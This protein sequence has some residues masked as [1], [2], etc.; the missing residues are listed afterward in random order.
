MEMPVLIA[1]G[2]AKALM[3]RL[4]DTHSKDPAVVITADQIVLYKGVIRE[5]PDDAEMAVHYL[6][7]YNFDK[8]STVSAV[9]VTHY[10]SGVQAHGIDV[11]TVYWGELSPAIIDKVVA[12]GAVLNS[13]GG[14][15]VEDPDLN[16]C[17]ASLDGTVDSIMG[18]PV[19]LTERLIEEVVN[20]L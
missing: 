8:V 16:E 3:K 11:A 5:K 6:S 2:K 19:A 9:V 1:Q 15:C 12:K 18:L 13:A 17:V 10:P 20:Q 4:K 14:F 7:S